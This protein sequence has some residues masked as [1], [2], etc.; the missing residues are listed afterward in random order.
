MLLKM[1]FRKAQRQ[2]DGPHNEPDG[3]NQVDPCRHAGL[4][5]APLAGCP[6]RLRW[7][8]LTRLHLLHVVNITDVLLDPGIATPSL[9]GRDAVT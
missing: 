3:N 7:P 5:A 1:F 9:R 2:E 8:C 4:A 6:G